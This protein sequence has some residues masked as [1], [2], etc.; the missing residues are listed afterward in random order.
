MGF[1]YIKTTIACCM[2]MGAM[3]ATMLS[4]G[5]FMDPVTTDLGFERSSFSLYITAISLVGMLTLPVY[6]RVIER[7]GAR[8][9]ALV[10]GAWTGLCIALLGVCQSLTQFYIAGA[11]AGLGFFG[12]TYAVV[13]VVV[14][15]WFALKDGLVMGLASAAGGV[16][17]IAVSM[18]FPSLIASAGWKV[19]YVV[20]GLL[21]A[22][23]VVFAALFLL[24]SRPSDIGLAPYGAD[25]REDDVSDAGFQS[26][27]ARSRALRMPS[28]WFL[29]LSL[30]VLSASITVTQHLAAFFASL[31]FDAIMIGIFMSVAAC[32]VIAASF[33][34]GVLIEKL[35]LVKALVLCTVL[36]ALSFIVLSEAAL[37]LVVG[38]AVAF[39]AIGN[40]YT[41]LFAPA[42]VS[43]AFGTRDYA[44]L[45]G[46]A[47]MATTLGQAVGAP[48]WGLSYDVS[49]SYVVGM[50]VAAGVSL[51]ALVALIACIRS[52]ARR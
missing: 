19:G 43:V 24:R 49:G 18:T 25:M 26:G 9:V 8:P 42:A 47:S 21:F 30:L 37:A 48:L 14:S 51:V 23:L 36:Y 3:I 10:A 34:G 33:L 50:W 2:I 29:C 11:L 28:F 4:F 22:I 40:C 7:F 46:I 32:G 38:L 44:A 17:S 16:L 15:Q 45:W 52:A 20:D 12:S 39:L 6:G 5:F 13:P 41:S 27:I 35:G 31:G 1:P